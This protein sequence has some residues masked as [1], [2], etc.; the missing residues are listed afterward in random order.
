[1][2]SPPT[3]CASIKSDVRVSSAEI[4]KSSL[5]IEF[6]PG[7][8][9]HHFLIELLIAKNIHIASFTPETPRLED[10]FMSLTKG[11]VQ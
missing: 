5:V 2:P 7:Q 9:S 11:Q 6:A 4:E 3:V 10:A 8:K 1:M